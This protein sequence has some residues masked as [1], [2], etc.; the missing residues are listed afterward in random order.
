LII[1]D[2]FIDAGQGTVST[3]PFGTR[4]SGSEP[5]R[6]LRSWSGVRG[7]AGAT[8]QR[9]FHGA[10]LNTRVPGFLDV[11]VYA[12]RTRWDAVAERDGSLA[13]FLP[14]A[15]GVHATDE[16]RARR[17]ALGVD[18]WGFLLQWE[19][20]AGLVGI[21]RLATKTGER[22]RLREDLPE[23]ASFRDI[24]LFW[25]LTFGGWTTTGE[26]TRG[27]EAM[28]AG[29]ERRYGNV[30]RWFMQ[31]SR[32]AR[33]YAPLF[34]DPLGF[35]SLPL[36]DQTG[37]HTGIGLR[38]SSQLR[39]A[40]SYRLSGTRDFASNRPFPSW[41][42]TLR[43]DGTW[44]APQGFQLQMRLR[45][46]SGMEDVGVPGASGFDS[47][48]HVATHHTESSF[49]FS[50]YPDRRVESLLRLGLGR[51]QRSPEACDWGAYLGA[52]LRLELAPGVEL[53]L[54][55]HVFDAASTARRFYVF[56]PG[57][58]GSATATSLSGQ[59]IRTMARL[60]ISLASEAAIEMKWAASRSL[61]YKNGNSTADRP[62]IEQSR[63][64][65]FGVQIQVG[66]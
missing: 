61:R 52:S 27:T 59:G 62:L 51:T 60:R 2:Y 34:G 43:F 24:S 50:F 66:S 25:S 53:L 32:Y 10:A 64:N 55:G 11:W 44:K 20:H 45:D 65:W 4:I 37:L 48:A 3:R 56:E 12:S 28:I 30:F 17:R 15:S 21:Q 5:W 9:T 36:A 8:G 57:L 49:A 40:V 31:A 18:S 63:T 38:P 14:V 54:Q 6:A 23:Q 47:R 33:D 29:V 1:G 13:V 39:L 58:S 35:H 7:Y 22:M 41:S 16:Q 26:V 42:G 19:S 46:G